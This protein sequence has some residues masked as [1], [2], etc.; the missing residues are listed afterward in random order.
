MPTLLRRPRLRRRAGDPEL[1]PGAVWTHSR[2]LLPRPAGPGGLYPGRGDA[3]TLVPGLAA[4]TG[5]AART[6]G[7]VSP[8]TSELL[9]ESHFESKAFGRG[10]SQASSVS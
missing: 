4:F 10:A 7:S 2:S 3:S 5:A 1:P 9:P 6:L 8:T